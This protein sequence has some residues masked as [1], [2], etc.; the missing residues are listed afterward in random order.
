MIIV[1]R[2]TGSWY[3]RVYRIPFAWSIGVFVSSQNNGN[4][5]PMASAIVTL[6]DAS[7]GAYRDVPP[8][9]QKYN[10][11]AM[12]QYDEFSLSSHCHIRIAVGQSHGYMSSTNRSMGFVNDM[13]QLSIRLS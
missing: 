13:I 11:T 12:L 7:D 1:W 3:G 8:G 6:Y 5:Y 9:V 2:V 10:A 4:E